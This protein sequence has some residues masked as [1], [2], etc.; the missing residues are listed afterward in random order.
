MHAMQFPHEGDA[1][2]GLIGALPALDTPEV[3][4]QKRSLASDIITSALARLHAK[5]E[6]VIAED[7]PAHETLRLADALP[8]ELIVVG[9]HGRRGLSRLVLGSMAA[10]IVE[11]APCSVLV[12]RDKS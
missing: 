11:R 9:T 10:R 5:G 1:A 3:R 6:I 7:D 4:A 2:M 12:T 8:A